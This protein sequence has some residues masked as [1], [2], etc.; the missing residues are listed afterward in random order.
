MSLIRSSCLILAAI[1]ASSACD[2]TTSAQPGDEVVGAVQVT[3]TDV[4]VGVG[5]I[6]Q[7]SAAVFSTS[8]RVIANAPVTWSTSNPSIVAVNQSGRVEGLSAG[9]ASVTAASGGKSGTASVTV[10]ASTP[11]GTGDI[12]LNSGV[13]HQRIL[14]WESNAWVGQWD[15]DG[16]FPTT[17]YENFKN[18]LFDRAADLGINR[19][20]LPIRSGAERPTDRFPEFIAG[21]VPY[22]TWRATWYD[23]INDNGNAAS[24]NATGFHFAE[25]DTAIN[26]V[27]LPLKQRLEARGERLYVNLN[28]IDF[29]KQSSFNQLVVPE[30]YAEFIL[31]TFQHIRSKYGWVPDGVEMILEPDN[32]VVV[33]SGSQIGEAIVAVGNRLSAAGFR[34]DFTAPSGTNMLWSLQA[35]D[36]MITV[37]GVSQ[38]LKELSY[39]RYNG[40]STATLQSI[41]QR[42]AQHGIRSAMLEHIGSGY[43]DLHADLKTGRN[44]AWQQYSL[45]D[46]RL[47]DD[48]G[49][50]FLI[51]ATNVASP[52]ILV[53]SRTHFL[54]QY[55]KYVGRGAVRIDASSRIAALDPLAFVHEDGRYVVV[56]KATA[57][58]NFTIG[59][60]PAGRYGIVY[61]TGSSQTTPQQSGI[62]APDAVI[63]AGQA[64]SASMPGRGVITIYRKS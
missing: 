27:V 55:Y 41:G 42:A 34:P 44:S 15:C 63:S 16:R 64:L 39:H 46:C 18:E 20:R 1:F 51:D 10:F 35:F 57:A 22:D 8:N 7:L 14:G 50:L 23:A 37:P 60:L 54:R 3:P 2:A 49:R 13:V 33:Y 29:N 11:P 53:A 4:T 61:T 36:Q 59:G 31:A 52:H 47:Q 6:Q 40:V 17:V 28:F 5:Q 30:E 48:G 45:A 62:E 26:R 56:V 25:L 21:T 24:I 43:E 9:S 38:Y 12:T 58:T 32:G 19:L